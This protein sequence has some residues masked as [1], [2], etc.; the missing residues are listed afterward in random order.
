MTTDPEPAKPAN[1][2]EVTTDSGAGKSAVAV[3]ASSSEPY[4]EL[5][6]AALVRGRNAMSIW[7]ELVDGHGF[8]GAYE[9][10]KRYVR[11][12]RGHHRRKRARS[13]RPRPA[14]KRRST[15]EPARWCAIRAPA[16]TGAPDCSS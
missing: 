5:I 9:S 10:V 2:E 6:E 4:R 13:F 11:K 3:T 1:G 14:K 16:S 7:Q 8:G 12:L 15:T